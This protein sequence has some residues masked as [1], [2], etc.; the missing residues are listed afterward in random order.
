VRP[1][2]LD[3]P[4]LGLAI[5][6][7]VAR[8]AV[9]RNRLKRLIREGFRHHQV[10]LDGIDVVAM[11]RRGSAEAPNSEIAQGLERVWLKI[12]KSCHAS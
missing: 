5:S 8:R 11:A 4:R 6:R 1:N 9:D 12:A 2:G 3:H 10:A 7:K